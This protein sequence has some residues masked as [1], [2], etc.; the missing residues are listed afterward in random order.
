MSVITTME[1]KDEC[2]I[3]SVISMNSEDK[4]YIKTADELDDSPIEWLIPSWIPKRGI[5]L[6]CADGGTGKTFIWVSLLASLSNGEST[7]L[8]DDPGLKEQKKVMCFSGED[9]ENVFRE[10]FERAGA[11]LKNIYVCA[12]DSEEGSDITF[13]SNKLEGIIQRYRPSI[14]V[15]DPLQSFIGSNVDMSRRNQMRSALKPLGYISSKYNLPILIILHTNKRPGESGRDKMA[16]SSDIWD[17]AR[18]VMMCGFDENKNRYISLEKSSYANHME[19]PTVIF[20]LDEGR[21]H[22][23]TVTDKKMKDFVRDAKDQRKESVALEH[24]TKKQECAN[25]ILRILSEQGGKCPR[26]TL[27]S[28]LLEDGYSNKTIRTAREELQREG[29]IINKKTS[30]SKTVVYR[31]RDE[32]H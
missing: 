20:S 9:P 21:V 10:R 17:Q 18:S 31:T 13:Q 22:Y 16:D 30:E 28:I 5:T 15:F 19:V 8:I 27:I 29:Y 26:E 3:Y 4:F 14:V 11:N 23:I 12:Q 25:A 24:P 6:L 7:F 2:Q 32:I 1:E